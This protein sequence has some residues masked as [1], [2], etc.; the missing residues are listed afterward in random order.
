MIV[1]VF[2]L[3]GTLLGILGTLGVELVRS[4]TE[5]KRARQQVPCD[6]P[7]TGQMGRWQA[8]PSASPA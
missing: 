5:D 8:C 4:R 1:A 3:L 7:R 2:A 6:D